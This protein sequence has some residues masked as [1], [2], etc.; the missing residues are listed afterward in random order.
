M[1]TNKWY[2]ARVE[3]LSIPLTSPDRDAV[4]EFIQ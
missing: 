3:P 4:L 2:Y 1:R